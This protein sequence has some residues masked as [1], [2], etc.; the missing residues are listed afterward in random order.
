MRFCVF[1]RYLREQGR[2]REPFSFSAAGISGCRRPVRGLSAACFLGFFLF[3]PVSG[4]FDVFADSS[5][6]ISFDLFAE[7]PFDADFF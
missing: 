4:S 6:E 5:V 3:L 1:R 2:K 7:T